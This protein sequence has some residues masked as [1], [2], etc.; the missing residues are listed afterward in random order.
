[1]RYKI[2]ASLNILLSAI[3][4]FMLWNLHIKGEV[5]I[6]KPDPIPVGSSIIPF[7]LRGLSEEEGND[8]TLLEGEHH[9]TV[10]F[11]YSDECD[12]CNRMV[13]TWEEAY[14]RWMTDE[15]KFVALRISKGEKTIIRESMYG[16]MYE[17]VFFDQIYND[18][19]IIG[20][21]MTVVVDN[22]GEVIYSHL[23]VHNLDEL[24][25][26]DYLI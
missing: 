11:I 20:V 23:G 2:S 8:F 18:L 9:L 12:A 19:N 7:E 6:E 1:M 10:L 4:L 25:F 24:H 3:I 22:S 21:P 17:P 5:Y 14:L 13:P 26:I 15:I 16:I